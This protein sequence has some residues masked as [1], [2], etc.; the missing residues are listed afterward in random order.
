MPEMARAQEKLDALLGFKSVNPLYGSF[1]VDQLG[2]ANREERIQALES[3]LELPRPLLKKV[4]VPPPEELP[5][6]PL[7]RERLDTELIRRGLIAAPLGE[8]DDDDHHSR[9]DDHDAKYPPTLAEKLRL[10][11]DA[12]YG[13]VH[14]VKTQPVWAAGKLLEFNGD[15]DKYIKAIDLVKQEGIVF[16]HFLRLI[17]LCA[18]FALVSPP[19]VDAAEWQ[20]ELRE[21]ADRLTETCR[22]IDPQSTEK[23][24]EQIQAGDALTGQARGT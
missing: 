23:T 18:E 15:F 17:L 1:L 2:I 10:L 22:D 6:G 8:S 24:I 20:E 13:H 5:P 3:V 12:E 21:L 11:F 7:A 14:G 19:D 16:R 9:V 4:R